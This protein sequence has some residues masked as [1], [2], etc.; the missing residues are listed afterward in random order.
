MASIIEIRE[1][2]ANQLKTIEGLN[3]YAL[4]QDTIEADA[5]VIKPFSGMFEQTFGEGDLTQ[6]RFEIHLFVSLA[7]GLDTAQH[8][9]DQYLLPKGDRSIRDCLKT[10]RTLD[11]LVDMI[12]VHGWRSYDSVKVPSN[13]PDYLRTIFDVEVWAR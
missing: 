4:W 7:A 10:D 5:A 12:V 13:G 11:T 3:A 8:A 2:I 9:M 1:A 6:Y